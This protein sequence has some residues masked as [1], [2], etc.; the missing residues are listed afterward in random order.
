MSTAAQLTANGR[1]VPGTPFFRHSPLLFYAGLT[2]ALL[3]VLLVSLN[4]GQFPVSP[5]ELWESVRCRLTGAEPADANVET[6]LWTIRIPRLL[7]AV[8]VGASL[9]CAG[10]TYQGMFRNPLVSPDI[11]GVSAG[12]GLGASIA[13]FYDLPMF[14]VQAFAFIGGLGAVSIVAM[15]GTRARRHDPVLVLVLAGIAVGSLLGAGI[16]L[17]KILADPFTQL[18]SI[19]FWFLGSLTAVDWDAL[20]LIATMLLVGL[21]PLFLLRWR[22][23]LLTLE[24]D[25][26]RTLG[27]PIRLTRAVLIVLTTLCTAA[28]VSMTGIIGWVGLL[29]PHMARMLVGA[30]FVVLLPTSFFLGGTFLLAADTM[31]RTIAPIELPLGIITATFGAPFFLY[32][33]LRRSE[34]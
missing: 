26:A 2:G 7:V 13:F 19:T 28:V 32:L 23:N 25:E 3:V 9:S 1:A 4:L 18:P 14:Y 21:T 8:L 29:V 27:V 16:S 5:G 22:L 15:L 34:T 31:A 30:N 33:L 12:A 6:V 17:I 20:A 10:A 24:D 11:L